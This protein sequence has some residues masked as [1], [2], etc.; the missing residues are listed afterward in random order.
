[1]NCLMGS[2]LEG[3]GATCCMQLQMINKN[4]VDRRRTQEWRKSYIC[5]RIFINSYYA[6]WE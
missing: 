3:K 4:I 6:N 1:M 5:S 2:V